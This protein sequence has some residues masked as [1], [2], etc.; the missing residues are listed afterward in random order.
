MK[1]NVGLLKLNYII[2]IPKIITKP[3]RMVQR[4]GLEENIL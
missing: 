3:V 2:V 1:K 4:L